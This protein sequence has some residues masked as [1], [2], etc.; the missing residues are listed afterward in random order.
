MEVDQANFNDEIDQSEMMPFSQNFTPPTT[1]NQSVPQSS[2]S[3]VP[4]QPLAPP[5]P[6]PSVIE[7]AC[8]KLLP[9][10]APD[11]S[12]TGL[13]IISWHPIVKLHNSYKCGKIGL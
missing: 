11:Q 3:L 8:R 10:R 4:T 7:S 13:F 6:S 2:L 1:M 5:S 9:N 12:S